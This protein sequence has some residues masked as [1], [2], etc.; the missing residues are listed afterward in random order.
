MYICT[1]LKEF[2]DS[3]SLYTYVHILKNFYHKSRFFKLTYKCTYL[4]EF[5]DSSSL[6][7]CVHILKNF[8]ILQAYIHTYVHILK[9]FHH[10]SG[11]DSNTRPTTSQIP[12]NTVCQDTHVRSIYTGKARYYT[13][14]R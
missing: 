7:T 3:S 10:K 8:Q 9:N 11:R 1:Y 14:P 2:P 5:P 13:N 12:S 4:K 6:Y